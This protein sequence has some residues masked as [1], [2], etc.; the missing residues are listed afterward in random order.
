MIVLFPLFELHRRFDGLAVAQRFH[1]HDVAYLAAAQ[2]VGEIVQIMN[3]LVAKLDEHV[4]GLESRFGRGRP[5]ERRKICTPF[6]SC[7]KS[8]IDPKYG[9]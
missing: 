7:P 3:L 6:S 5:G 2:R 1:I 4:A 9:P 8:G